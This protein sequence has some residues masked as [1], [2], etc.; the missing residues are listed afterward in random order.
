[1]HCKPSKKKNF[2]FGVVQILQMALHVKTVAPKNLVLYAE[3]AREIA[4]LIY[5]QEKDVDGQQ[6]Y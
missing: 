4:Y 1:L 3:A 6:G 2:T 5:N